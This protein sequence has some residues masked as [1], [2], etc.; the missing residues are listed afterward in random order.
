LRLQVE[1]RKIQTAF[2]A[3]PTKKISEFL[4]LAAVYTQGDQINL[5]VAFL[6]YATAIYGIELSFAF[7]PELRQYLPRNPQIKMN[8]DI[9]LQNSNLLHFNPSYSF[10]IFF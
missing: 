4:P 7:S 9:D 5:F 8:P 6:K 3:E 2:F 10:F 1:R